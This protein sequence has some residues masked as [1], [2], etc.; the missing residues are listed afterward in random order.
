MLP[1]NMYNQF[2]QSNDEAL[3]RSGDG[4]TLLPILSLAN[5]KQKDMT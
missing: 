2:V 1:Q 5:K 3:K 4:L